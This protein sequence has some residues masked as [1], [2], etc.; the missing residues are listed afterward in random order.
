MNNKNP[1]RGQRRY[2]PLWDHSR[3]SN[4][5]NTKKNRKALSIDGITNELIK[6][7]GIKTEQEILELNKKVVNIGE[8]PTEWKRW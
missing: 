3:R 1:R 6:Y 4:T 2:K 5:C 7:G 8:I